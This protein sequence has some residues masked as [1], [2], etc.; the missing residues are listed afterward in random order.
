MLSG[1]PFDSILDIECFY[2]HS[3]WYMIILLIQEVTPNIYDIFRQSKWWKVYKCSLTDELAATTP[4]FCMQVSYKCN[5]ENI[6]SPLLN[7]LMSLDV[8]LK[9]S[10]RLEKLLT[11]NFVF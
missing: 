1:L 8:V 11:H 6:G 3:T 9:L 2:F 5:L 4:Y 10:H 7:V